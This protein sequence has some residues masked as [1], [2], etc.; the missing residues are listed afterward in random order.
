MYIKSVVEFV[1]LT[2]INIKLRIKNII[3]DKLIEINK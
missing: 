1:V 3:Y 2:I